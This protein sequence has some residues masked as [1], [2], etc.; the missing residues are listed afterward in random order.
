M[1][2]QPAWP[3]PRSQRE[4]RRKIYDFAA[5]HQKK[6]KEINSTYHTPKSSDQESG[7]KRHNEK[8]IC[9]ALEKNEKSERSMPNSLSK[10]LCTIFFFRGRRIILFFSSHF[11]CTCVGESAVTSDAPLALERRTELRET[12]VDEFVLS[13]KRF[14]EFLANFIVKIK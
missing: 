8:R 2:L 12:S 11:Y 13:K 14:S 4:P 1:K 7:N 3:E 5:N 10:Q 6:I 9:L